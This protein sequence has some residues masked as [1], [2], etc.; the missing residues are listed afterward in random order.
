MLVGMSSDK[1]LRLC[2][3]SVLQAVDGDPSRIHLVEA[4]NPRA[5]KLQAVLEATNLY[6]ACFD[7]EDPSV[8]SQ[9]QAAMQQTL[10][11]D[12]ILVVCGSVFLMAE[13]REALGIEEPRDSPY[14]AAMAGA[15]VRYSQENFQTK[16]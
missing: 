8:T 1:D 15:G 4:A 6:D 9:M 10:D 11:N 13:T 16:N 5:A 2:G 7:L 12:E 14:I 3:E